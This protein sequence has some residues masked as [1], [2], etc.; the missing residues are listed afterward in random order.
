MNLREVESVKKRIDDTFLEY[1]KADYGSVIR[2]Y[3][4]G[5]LSG[6]IFASCRLGAI[7]TEEYEYLH[8]AIKAVDINWRK[9]VN[10]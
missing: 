5:R 3:S 6:L 9:G 7:D 1:C 8:D 10:A 2:E 4:Y